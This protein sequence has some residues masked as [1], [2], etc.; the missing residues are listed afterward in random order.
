MGPGSEFEPELLK[1]CKNLQSSRAGDELRSRGCGA[2]GFW[3]RIPWNHFGKGFFWSLRGGDS[4]VRAAEG[5]RWRR[6]PG[7]EAGLE[8]LWENRFFWSLC[9]CNPRMRGEKGPISPQK[10]SPPRPRCSPSASRRLLLPSAPRAVPARGREHRDD[11]GWESGA[12]FPTS[13]RG[14]SAAPASQKSQILPQNGGLWGLF[15]E[16]AEPKR[17]WES[18]G[19]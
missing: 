8:S 16:A 2:G 4:R 11:P 10:W 1:L 7:G 19:N 5:W 13:S 12:G 17:F 9:G 18:L 3:G 15:G 14:S 6:S